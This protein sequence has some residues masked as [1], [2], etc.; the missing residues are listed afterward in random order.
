[1]KRTIL[2]LTSCLSL[3]GL[4]ILGLPGG[5]QAWAAFPEKPVTINVGFAAG[6]SI[7]SSVRALAKDMEKTLGQPVVVVNKPGGGG[8][9]AL[10]GLVNVKPNGYTLAAGTSTGLIR[11][12]QQRKVNYKPLADF[13][14]V[15]TFAFA[16][17]GIVVKADSPF[18]TIQDL[19]EY[20]KAHP[21]EIK[22]STTGVGSPM[23]LSMQV[24]ARK[25]GLKW[26]HIPYTG[27]TPALTAVLGGHVQVCASGPKFVDMVK[28]GQLKALAVVT[29]ERVPVL[30]DVPT[31]REAGY[32]FVSDTYFALYGPAGMDQA[33]LKTLEEAV[34][35]AVDSKVFMDMCDKF[36]MIPVK[37]DS[38][39]YTKYLEEEWPRQTEILKQLNIIK[40]PATQPK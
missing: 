15:S 14:N 29:A 18:N 13:T 24:I 7:D 34:A 17:V 31:L 3:L 9:V 1:M 32:D 28:G 19:V 4:M 35:K 30:K 21:N 23:H 6:G 27:S 37:M 16:W 2:L 22:Y 26:T 39:E 12:P 33:V 11:I 38:A 10:T 5:G 36:V 25:E 20:A 40:A 8:T